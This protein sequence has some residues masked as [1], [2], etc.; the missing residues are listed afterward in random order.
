MGEGGIE[1]EEEVDARDLCGHWGGEVKEMTERKDSMTS[2]NTC[3]I[4]AR[5]R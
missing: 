4:D 1:V 5:G 2:R 3:S